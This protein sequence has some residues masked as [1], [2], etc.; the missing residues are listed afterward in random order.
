MLKANNLNDNIGEGLSQI[1][2]LIYKI[3]TFFTVFMALFQLLLT[4]KQRQWFSHGVAIS[5]KSRRVASALCDAMHKCIMQYVLA[6]ICMPSY[7]TP[8]SCVLCV[9][10]LL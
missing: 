3:Y 7:H 6:S 8:K 10:C 4:S 2:K 5:C 9:L 1:I